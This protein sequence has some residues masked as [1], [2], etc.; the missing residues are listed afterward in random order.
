MFVV[1]ALACS[2]RLGQAPWF[3]F[4]TVN[5]AMAAFHVAHWQT[6]VTGT[7]RFG[8]VDVT[9]AQL[10]TYAIFMV[11]GLFGDYVWS[12][13]VSVGKPVCT[14]HTY[15]GTGKISNFAFHFF[16]LKNFSGKVEK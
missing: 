5:L 13:N 9:E 12:I 4:L 11:S 16:H 8:R 3:M 7:L 14:V 1:L 10:C 15:I 2:L 6:Y